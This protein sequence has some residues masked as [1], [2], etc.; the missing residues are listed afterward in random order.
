MERLSGSLPSAAAQ[1]PEDA[2]IA[3][4][5]A[6]RPAEEDEGM[7]R[8][9]G[10]LP[11]AAVQPPEDAA[12][13]SAAAARPAVP[14]KEDSDTE[15]DEDAEPSEEESSSEADWISSE[16]SSTP[17]RTTAEVRE[18]CARSALPGSD[19]VWD[20]AV[21]LAW[22]AGLAAVG[23]TDVCGNVALRA[24]TDLIL[25]ERDR[26]AL[27]GVA[28]KFFWTTEFVEHGGKRSAGA[29]EHGRSRERPARQMK[30][31]EDLIEM[32]TEILSR[33]RVEQ[34]ND[35]EPL[36]PE[37]VSRIYTNWMHA[38][39]Q[40]ELTERQRSRTPSQKSSIF[41]V[42]VNRLYGGKHFLM[43]L[44]R[45][46]ITWIPPAE[47]LADPD[48]ATEHVQTKFMIWLTDLA[49]AIDEHK[50]DPETVLAQ[51]NSG[52]RYGES[53]LTEEGKRA[54]AER[55][56]ALSDLFRAKELD[57]EFKGK[58]G[59]K[60]RGKGKGQGACKGKAK[61]AEPRS[62]GSMAR[63]EQG[64]SLFEGSFFDGVAEG[65]FFD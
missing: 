58:G 2:A 1:P 50:R 31:K 3:A 9:S 8:L 64:W 6:A 48:G 26:K 35:A 18:D 16:L 22:T 59:R 49:T 15:P 55:D 4:A 46:G 27:S 34:P 13:A 19:P 44:L 37:A 42:H 51:L 36:A 57:R 25:S 30:S 38:F 43:G 20:D 14:P 40:T 56:R 29:P 33:R 45:A 11:S 17:P 12:I 24:P 63:W 53:G 28:G 65:S 62:I 39:I 7:E 10:S 54:R 32:W 47:K 60:G 23:R 52:D 61:A 5:A 21:A 41:A